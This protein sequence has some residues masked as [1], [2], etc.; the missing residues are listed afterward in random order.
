MCSRS[1]ARTGWTP[2]WTPA[3]QSK[4]LDLPDQFQTFLDIFGNKNL[5]TTPAASI[6][7]E[8][9]TILGTHDQDWQAGKVDD[10]NAMLKQVDSEI[11]A[12][13]ALAG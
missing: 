12:S 10:V 11:D 3:I 8:Y 13:A 4:D 5:V 7:A 2:T 6:G 1:S 9:Q